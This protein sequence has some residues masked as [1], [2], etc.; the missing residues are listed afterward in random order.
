MTLEK[1]GDFL[2]SNALRIHVNDNVVIATRSITKG[3]PVLVKGGL[4]QPL[5]AAEDIEAGH[6]IAIIPIPSGGVVFRYGEP[7][8][9]ATRAISRGEWVHVHNTQPIPGDLKE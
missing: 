1:G 7:I 3:E 8:V 9:Q 5:P 6:K 2:E 4:E